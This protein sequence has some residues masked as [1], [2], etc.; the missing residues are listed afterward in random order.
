MSIA[1]WVKNKCE[2]AN[3]LK[4]ALYLLEILSMLII[5]INMSKDPSNLIATNATAY[6]INGVTASGEW[7]REGICASKSEYIDD[8]I[9]V[10]QKL[11]DGS[12]GKLIGF[13]EC[14]DTGGAAVAN[15]QIVDIWKPNMNECQAFMDTVYEDG[16]GGQVYIYVYD[17]CT[18]EE[19]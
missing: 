16:C 8:Y 12:V 1:I 11:P 7:T 3:D 14:K 2:S 15:G 9:F 6:C 17:T 5:A 18:E 10:Y 4:G 13:Y 19:L